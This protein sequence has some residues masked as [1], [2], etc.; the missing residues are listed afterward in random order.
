M[1]CCLHNR[2][3][4]VLD[5]LFPEGVDI[6]VDYSSWEA[7]C[8]AFGKHNKTVKYIHGDP[9]DNPDFLEY[10][11]E[12][13]DVLP[14][15]NK[16]VCVSR[17]S[18]DSY[19]RIMGISEGVECHYNPIVSDKIR[20]LSQCDVDG[21]GGLPYLCAVGRLAPEKGY[22]RLIRIHRRILDRGIAHRL[23]I[24]GEGRER[25]NLEA[26]IRE[27]GTEDTVQLVGFQEN[28]YPYMKNSYCV[29]CSSYTEGLPVIAMESLILG[30][31]FVS[32]V[33]SA[34]EIFADMDCGIVT[35]NGDDS[36]EAGIVQMLTEKERYVQM[37]R[38]ARILG[39]RF[40]GKNMVLELEA[41][42]DNIDK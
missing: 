35:E 15:Y 16:T 30:V 25:R 39:S 5:L 21:L 42:F 41:L 18:Y 40:E 32:A 8:I 38:N 10:L 34:R 17:K 3:K 19:R 11:T 31:P 9:E 28:P 29:V 22:D 1:W 12:I 14:L 36:L 23:I 6:A 27:T 4:G 33:P 13:K 24:V 20:S 37:R 7:G 2:Y 26:V